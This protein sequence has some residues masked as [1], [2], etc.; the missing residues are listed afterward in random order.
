MIELRGITRTYQK[1]GEP[2]VSAL[3]GVSL[4]IA[5]GEF[6]AV[7]GPSN[8]GK[9]TVMNVLG[10]LDKPDSGEYRLQGREV[11]DLNARD[12]AGLRNQVIGVV[13]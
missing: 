8:S 7:L 5:A 2:T 3:Q 11:S 6:V 12:M 9:S 4:N 13:F 1:P 10:L